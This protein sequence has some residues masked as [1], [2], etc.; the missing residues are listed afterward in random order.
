MSITNCG[1]EEEKK[2]NK[3]QVDKKFSTTNGFDKRLTI[4][5]ARFNPTASTSSSSI[6]MTEDPLKAPLASSITLPIVP[7]LLTNSITVSSQST[8]ISTKP[9]KPKPEVVYIYT[10]KKPQILTLLYSVQ[11]ER[12]SQVLQ[13]RQRYFIEI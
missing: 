9:I 13:H 8:P 7:P 5:K 4:E 10:N 3:L 2:N 6:P 12:K 1:S 11:R